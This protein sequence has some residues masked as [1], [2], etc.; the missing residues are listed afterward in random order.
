MKKTIFYST[1]ALIIIATLYS[2]GKVPPSVTGR[3]LNEAGKRVENWTSDEPEIKTATC[4]YCNGSGQVTDGYYNYKCNNCGG[5]GVVIIS[6][7]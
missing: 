2:C 4:G 1:L 5:D 3:V 6:E 7:N